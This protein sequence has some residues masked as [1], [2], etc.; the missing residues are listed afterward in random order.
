MQIYCKQQG[1]IE[2]DHDIIKQMEISDKGKS[3]TILV[4]HFLEF[5]ELL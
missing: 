3:N 1:R 5:S 2:V 4:M